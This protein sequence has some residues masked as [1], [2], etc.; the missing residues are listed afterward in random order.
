MRFVPKPSAALLVICTIILLCTGIEVV[1]WGSDLG[2]WGGPRLRQILYEYGGFWPGLLGS[3]QPNYSGQPVVMFFSYALLHGGPGHLVMNMI[4]LWSL[5]QGVAD[6]V[7]AGRFVLVYGGT[8]LGGA[9]GYGLLAS[10][11]QPMVGASGALFG[12]AGALLA[13]AYID[14]FNSRAGLWPVAQV[15]LF[16][17]AINIV[18]YWALDGHLAWQTHLGGFVFGW[19]LALLIDPVPQIEPDQDR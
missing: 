9:A 7:G 17:I 19:L 1:L 11:V 14:R 6:R 16:L 3:W 10:T 12:L 5:G 2:L 13:W 18:M 15:A 4:T 8:A